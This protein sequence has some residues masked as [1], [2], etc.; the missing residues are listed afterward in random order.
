[1]QARA[2]H[3]HQPTDTGFLHDGFLALSDST[4]GLQPRNTRHEVAGY[5]GHLH[6]SRV[7][8]LQW[9]CY[10]NTQVY[11]AKELAHPDLALSHLTL[12]PSSYYPS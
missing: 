9:Y 6:F 2:I 12:L 8:M 1:V 3:S 4:N 10:Q 11:T 5:N 7:G